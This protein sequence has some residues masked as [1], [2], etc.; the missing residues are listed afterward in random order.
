MLLRPN[1]MTICSKYDPISTEHVLL[2]ICSYLWRELV[3]RCNSMADSRVCVEGECAWCSCVCMCSS[4]PGIQRSMGYLDLQFSVCETPM[5]MIDDISSSR[6]FHPTYSTT[7][8]PLHPTYSTTYVSHSTQ[9]TLL[10]VYHS[11]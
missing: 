7:C 11:T 8:L 4:L 5:P 9:P 1:L 3:G 2:T 6:T 10:H